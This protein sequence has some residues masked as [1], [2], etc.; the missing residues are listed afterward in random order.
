MAFENQLDEAFVLGTHQKKIQGK[1]PQ[2]RVGGP[3][4]ADHLVKGLFVFFQFPDGLRDGK[5]RKGVFREF[6]GRKTDVLKRYTQLAF[7]TAV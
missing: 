5:N 1:R 7:G 2:D 6:P 3:D 4:G